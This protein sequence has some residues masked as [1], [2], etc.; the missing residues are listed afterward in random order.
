M[1]YKRKNVKYCGIPLFSGCIFLS[2]KIFK[3][4]DVWLA[5]STGSTTKR[6]IYRGTHFNNTEHLQWTLFCCRRSRSSTYGVARRTVSTVRSPSST[7]TGGSTISAAI[8][9]SFRKRCWPVDKSC[10]FLAIS[11]RYIYIMSIMNILPAH[12]C[13]II[14]NVRNNMLRLY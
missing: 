5:R 7:Q 4:D 10:R 12:F 3:C 8:S 14:V 13:T 11:M 6:K 2:A 1:I 9:T